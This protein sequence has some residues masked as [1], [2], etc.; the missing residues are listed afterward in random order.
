VFG[1]G[2][3]NNSG[4]EMGGWGGDFEGLHRPHCCPNRS[5]EHKLQGDKAALS[6]SGPVTMARC[7]RAINKVEVS[8]CSQVHCTTYRTN[9]W[10]RQPLS[11]ALL[12]PGP[13]IAQ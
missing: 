6:L 5:L 10:A 13:P 8:S 11:P 7:G 2:R 4:Q 12:Q 1:G 9:I 3:D